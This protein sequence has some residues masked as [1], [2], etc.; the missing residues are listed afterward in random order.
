M[1]LAQVVLV[2]LVV[3][4]VAGLQVIVINLLVREGL[5]G[6]PINGTGDQL[7]L[8]VLAELVVEFKT[9]LNVRDCVVFVAVLV[10]GGF[11]W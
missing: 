9:L 6:K 7:L 4:E 10:G 3:L 2:V 11:G 8:N 5:S 1:V